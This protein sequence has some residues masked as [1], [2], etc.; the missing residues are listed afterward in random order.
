MTQMIPP[1]FRSLSVVSFLSSI[2]F[3]ASNCCWD[4]VATRSTISAKN[5]SPIGLLKTSFSCFIQSYRC[6][7]TSISS[8]STLVDDVTYRI[9]IV[10]SVAIFLICLKNVCT[11]LVLSVHKSLL[12]FYFLCRGVTSIGLYTLAALKCTHFVVVGLVTL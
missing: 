10:E 11:N 2:F 1:Y 7:S 3:S 9:Y 4:C 12:H 5:A 8:M 6:N